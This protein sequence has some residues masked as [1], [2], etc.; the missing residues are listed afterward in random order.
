VW[1]DDDKGERNNRQ[2]RGDDRSKVAPYVKQEAEQ[3]QHTKPFRKAR[4]V[5]A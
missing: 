2:R 4:N 1:H 5:G 3:S